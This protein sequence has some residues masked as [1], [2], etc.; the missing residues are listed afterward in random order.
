[1]RNVKRLLAANKRYCK[2]CKPIPVLEEERN[3]K[4]SGGDLQ[5]TKI[6]NVK[7]IMVNKKNH[8]N[9]DSQQIWT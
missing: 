5:T 1:M 9:K 7:L 4:V 8:N 3:M 6:L 2:E